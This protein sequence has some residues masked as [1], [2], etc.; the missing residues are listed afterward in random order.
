MA[1][2]TRRPKNLGLAT[3]ATHALAMSDADRRALMGML[4]QSLAPKTPALP[5]EAQV[6]A[7]ASQLL[8]TASG[9]G[10]NK[11]FVSEVYRIGGF[12]MSLDA[13][14]TQLLAAQRA[15][16][17]SLSRA[18][19][20]EAMDPALVAKS[21]VRYLGAAFHFVRIDDVEPRY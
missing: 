8:G 11:V 13:F 18:D 20:V 2:Q 12:E 3:I 6:I 1:T 15:G 19:L 5:F 10:D 17:V 21:E 4:A 9:Y 14:K 7:T 16:L